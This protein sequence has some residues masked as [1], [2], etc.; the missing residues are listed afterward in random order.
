MG[1]FKIKTDKIQEM[2][3]KSVKGAGNNKI[4]PITCRI[5]IDFKDNALTL[6]TTDRVNYLEIS[7]NGIEGE[8]FNLVVD[9]DKLAKLIMKTTTEYMQFVYE[10][11]IFTVIGNGKYN[12]EIPNDESYE[13]FPKVE[14][15]PE[16][17]ITPTY[18]IPTKILQSILTYNKVCVSKSLE[19]P[20]LTCYYMDSNR[21]VSSNV[22]NACEN[23]Q[24][25]NFTTPCLLEQEL[26]D[27]IDVIDE[28]EVAITYYDGAICIKEL[29]NNVVIYGNCIISGIEEFPITSFDQFF[30]S[31]MSNS[32][33]IDTSTLLSMMDRIMIFTD[34]TENAN[35]LM[36]FNKTSLTISNDSHATETIKYVDAGEHSEFSCKINIKFLYDH[37]N[38]RYE[39]KL[40]IYYGDDTAIRIEGAGIKQVMCLFNE[41]E[42]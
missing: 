35:A 31:P 5:E 11:G 8:N 42:E 26:L 36:T 34:I 17:A 39:D 29:S 37:I 16:K 13:D 18:R 6:R 2:I 27:L 21:V 3:S 9:I 30:N 25:F 22:N 41:V 33:E 23:K 14:F 32:C 7:T 40:R 20:S 19:I 15:D 12:I 4:L 1:H 10:N 28:A 38:A 24:A